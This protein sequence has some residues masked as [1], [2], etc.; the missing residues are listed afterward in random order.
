MGDKCA[1]ALLHTVRKRETKAWCKQLLDVRATDIRGLLDLNHPE[2]LKT[3]TRRGSAFSLGNKKQ[4]DVDRAETGA[5]PCSHI[6]IEAFNG[7]GAR[8]LAE[9][10]VHVVCT[11]TGVVTEPDAKVLDLQWF[12]LVNLRRK[13]T[14]HKCW[15]MYCESRMPATA[16]WETYD[17][18][19]NDLAVGLFDLLQLSVHALTRSEGAGFLER[20]LRKYQKRDLA[21]TSF[22]AKMRIR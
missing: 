6:L 17:I 2:D 11:R 21:T 16:P 22:R 3:L 7:I 18:D 13:G 5:V 9:F 12:F 8:E 15:R 19:T 14:R 10:L 20:H 4:T 1:T